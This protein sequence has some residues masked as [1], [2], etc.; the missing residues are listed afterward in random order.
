M[1]ITFFCIVGLL[2]AIGFSG[3][4]FLDEMNQQAAM[5]PSTTPLPAR[6]LYVST[7]S[8]GKLGIN[9]LILVNPTTWQVARQVPLLSEAPYDLSRDPQGRIWL[10]Y[11]EDH[12]VQIFAPDGRLLKTLTI[13]LDPY[14]TIHFAAGHAF[15]PCLQS[16]FYASVVVVDLQSLEQVKQLDIRIDG[17]NFMLLATAGNE[18]YFSMMGN[19]NKNNRVVLVDTHTLSILI[20]ILIP[21]GDLRTILPYQGH[22]LLLNGNP[23]SQTKER[24]DLVIVDITKSPMVQTEQM[25]TSGALW[26]ALKGDTLY[27]YHNTVLGL[28]PD[29]ARAVSRLNLTTHQSKLWP[30]P[31]HWDANDIAVVNGQILLTHSIFQKPEESGLYRFDPTTG[32]LTMLVN[33]PGAQRILP[34]AP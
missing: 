25:P 9:Q 17:D 6:P 5:P 8:A 11:S 27:I 33:I 7:I 4:T 29:S 20:P 18:A 28:K 19:G 23:D 24:Q 31:D 26:G 12:R 34:S 15:I 2:C 14:L 1:R 21:Y 30:L 16:G 13:C 10:G 3:C 22:F 32:K